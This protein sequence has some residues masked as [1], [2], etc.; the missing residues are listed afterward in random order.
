MPLSV[1]GIVPSDLAR[2]AAGSCKAVLVLPSRTM[3]ARC[4][5]FRLTVVL[6]ISAHLARALDGLLGVPPTWTEVAVTHL[7][8]GRMEAANGASYAELAAI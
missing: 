3:M 4:P 5:S 1:L 6:T 8:C 2:L 7:A